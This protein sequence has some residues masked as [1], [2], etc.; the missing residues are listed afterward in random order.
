MAAVSSR[1]NISNNLGSEFSSVISHQL[2]EDVPE[3]VTALMS[4]AKTSRTVTLTWQP[5]LVTNGNITGYT[6]LVGGIEVSILRLCR[7]LNLL[8][9][10]TPQRDTL[11]IKDTTPSPN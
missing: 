8:Q 10:D 4:S 1:L 2:L 9:R 3:A 11:Y 5:P 6:I 7:R